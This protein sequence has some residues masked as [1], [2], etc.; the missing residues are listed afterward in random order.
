MSIIEVLLKIVLFNTL[1]WSV[2]WL[3]QHRTFNW[4]I[5]IHMTSNNFD[6]IPQ[7]TQFKKCWNDMNLS[8]CT[9]SADF[10]LELCLLDLCSTIL[11]GCRWK[12]GAFILNLLCDMKAFVSQTMREIGKAYATC[13]L[14]NENV[15]NESCIRI[16]NIRI[17]SVCY[18]NILC[19]WY[20]LSLYIS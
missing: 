6:N 5:P 2:N 3:F 14:L 7:I 12:L 16:C 11:N 1:H 20:E 18:V 13:G 15:P 4:S 8:P 10:G 9:I 19:T 17:K